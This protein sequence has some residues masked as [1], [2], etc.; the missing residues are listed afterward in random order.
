[1][2]RTAT[3]PL[4]AEL[5]EVECKRGHKGQW[6]QA[7]QKT[8]GRQCRECMKEA[9]L[10]SRIKTGKGLSE[11]AKRRGLQLREEDVEQARLEIERAQ[12][13]YEILQEMARLRKELDELF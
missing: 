2:G 9:V 4:I 7:S 13:R 11:R 8:S 1:M 5:S 3:R 10:K 12:R 6:V